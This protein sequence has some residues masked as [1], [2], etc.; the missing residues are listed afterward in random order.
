MKERSDQAD[1]RLAILG[2][3][4]VGKSAISVRFLTR[5]FIGEYEHDMEFIYRREINFEDEII[6]YELKDASGR[7]CVSNPRAYFAW[8]STIVVVYSIIQRSTFV[9]A[10]VILEEAKRMARNTT[11]PTIAIFA[12][13]HDLCHH[14]EVSTD[15]GRNLALK[16]GA[17]FYEVSAAA[18]Y[19]NVFIP[20]NTLIIQAYINIAKQVISKQNNKRNSMRLPLIEENV[21]LEKSGSAKK[22][23]NERKSVRRK[24]S[25][26]IFK[27]RSE[28]M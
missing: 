24:L 10:A 17:S 26:A 20:I 28:T 15:E 8:S 21:M 16:Y 5:R 23:P 3:P 2:A 9:T 18:D 27:K 7:K 6:S 13:K 1:V 19:D 22:S 12:N 14:R 4:A 11:M 25:A